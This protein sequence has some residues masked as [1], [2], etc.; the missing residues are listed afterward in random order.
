VQFIYEGVGQYPKKLFAEM[1]SSDDLA[2]M[3]SQWLEQMYQVAYYLDNEI[4]NDL[5]AQI[6]ESKA[7]LSKTLA[8][9]INNF[10]S[11]HIMELIRPLLQNPL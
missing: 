2:V 6:P 5:I 8:D 11:D 10:N 1:I 3:P 9:S 7:S 4:M